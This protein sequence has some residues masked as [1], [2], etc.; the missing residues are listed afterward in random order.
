M[1]KIVHINGYSLGEDPRHSGVVD[2]AG[3]EKERRFGDWE[4][5]CWGD[6]EKG[7]L[8]RIPT[9]LRLA[10][11][12]GADKIVWSTGASRLGKAQ[13]EADVMFDVAHQSYD[14]LAKDFPED[15][16]SPWFTKS[17]FRKYLER[18]RV[19]DIVSTNTL[20]SLQW[21]HKYVRQA[22]SRGEPVHVYS[23]TSANHVPRTARDIAI[24]FGYGTGSRPDHYWGRTMVSVWPAMTCY[25]DKTIHSVL[26]KELGA[27]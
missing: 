9:A 13:W 7:L 16:V 20:S 5:V 25:G 14:R 18:T 15:F 11:D 1:I 3:Q 26:I 17:S 24:A 6:P 12:I 21:L 22:F 4:H 27:D 19:N 10:R 23:V 8:G 2:H